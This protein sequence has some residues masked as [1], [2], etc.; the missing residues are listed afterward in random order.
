MRMLV[1]CLT[2]ALTTGTSVAEPPEARPCRVERLDFAKA[3]CLGYA[4]DVIEARIE[5]QLVQATAELQGAYASEILEFEDAL[6]RNQLDWRADVQ[7]ECRDQTPGTVA[8]Q[9]CRIEAAQAREGQVREA[10]A[11]LQ[12]R[13]G[14]GTDYQIAVPDAVEVLVPLSL[15]PRAGGPD[16]DVRLPLILPIFPN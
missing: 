13:F 3:A 7:A 6:R 1:V 8:F 11:V 15:P 2:L 14:T 10:L 16:V 5:A 4:A 9:S 12:D